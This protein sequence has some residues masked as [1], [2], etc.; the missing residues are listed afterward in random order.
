MINV[1]VNRWWMFLLVL[2]ETGLNSKLDFS[3]FLSSSLCDVCVCL[4][5]CSSEY[6]IKNYMTT[7]LLDNK[8]H[9]SQMLYK[10]QQK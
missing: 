9:H 7:N 8:P 4:C 5:V 1:V 2:H 3:L 10:N 6:F